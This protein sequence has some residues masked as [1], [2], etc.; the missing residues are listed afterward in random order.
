M[1]LVQLVGNMPLSA[2]LHKVL[3]VCHIVSYFDYQKKVCQLLGLYNLLYNEDTQKFGFGHQVFVY[4]YCFWSLI[5]LPTYLIFLKGFIIDQGS[6]LIYLL[7][8]LYYK[9]L[10]RSMLGTLNEMAKVHRR[11]QFTMGTTFCVSVKRAFCSSWLIA[12][13]LVFVI[14]W[15]IESLQIGLQRFLV[16]SCLLGWHLQL[17]LLVNSYIWL[18]SIYVVMNQIFTQNHFT[19]KERWKMFK[20]LMKLHGILQSIQRDISHYFSVYI[21][22]VVVLQSGVFYRAV[23]EAGFDWDQNRLVLLRLEFWHIRYF[24]YL[25]L[26]IGTIL[27]VVCDYKSERDKFLKGVW[28]NQDLVQK[29]LSSISLNR[30]KQITDV[31]DLMVM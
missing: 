9:Y 24:G 26:L 19:T 1:S 10:K 22:S 8:C 18:Q 5:C 20:T 30:C 21:C 15:Q 23:F 6:L 28:N 12:I 17:L 11:L 2:P 16:F 14:Y 25:I 31:L 27:L 13:E 4:F 7:P 3:C 29:S